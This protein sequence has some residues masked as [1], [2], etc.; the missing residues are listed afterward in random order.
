ME[1][2]DG[3][4]LAVAMGGRVDGSHPADTED[5]LEAILATKYVTDS[6]LGAL[7]KVVVRL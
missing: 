6:S 2:L 7:E 1:H 4:P 5:A 3:E